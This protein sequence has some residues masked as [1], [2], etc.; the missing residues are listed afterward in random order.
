LP[1]APARPRPARSDSGPDHGVSWYTVLPGPRPLRRRSKGGQEVSV[2]GRSLVIVFALSGVAAA[3]LPGA[4]APGRRSVASRV[5]AKLRGYWQ[6]R[7]PN[8]P[9]DKQV[10]PNGGI[11]W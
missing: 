11:T 7:D 1:K 6:E 3:G 10:G 5:R 4:P 8:L 2:A 9:K